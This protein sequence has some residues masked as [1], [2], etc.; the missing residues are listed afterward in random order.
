MIDD[1]TNRMTFNSAA[2]RAAWQAEQA[3]KREAASAK[4]REYRRSVDMPL[5][6]KK[7]GERF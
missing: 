3:Q 7:A 4:F 1:Q 2:E 5:E 6:Q